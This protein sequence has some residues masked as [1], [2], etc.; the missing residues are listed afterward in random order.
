VTIAVTGAT[1]F[2]GQAM[3]DVAMAQGLELRALARKP[4]QPR[5]GVDWVQGDL[6]DK[7]ALA[8]LVK[9]AEVVIHI[10][11]LTT[12]PDAAG[13]EAGNVTGTLSLAEAAIAAGV[14]RLVLVS[15]LSAR[16]P[17]L[18]LYGKSKARAEQVIKSSGLDWTIVRPPAVYGPRDDGMFELF[19]AAKWGLVPTPAAGKMSV[20]YAEDLAR[21]LLALAKGG[22]AVSHQTFEPDD[23]KPG[24]WPHYDLARAIGWAVGRRPF[25]LKMPP[26][27]MRLA[28]RGDMLLRRD[29][30]KLT[31]DRVGYMNHPD[32]V[33]SAA[34]L[35][36]AA[37][38]KPQVETREGLRATALWYRAQGWL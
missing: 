35:V 36:P 8:S 37:L 29:K 32:W 31:L 21:L 23:G 14:P 27:L 24:G 9:D 10:A 7:A 20:I 2:V 4:Q 33:V 25:V 6:A 13:F 1:G 11:G 16:E 18:S 28:A 15:S 30:A 26:T 17:E 3:L 34:A 5:N 38:W 22:E 12:A 19:R